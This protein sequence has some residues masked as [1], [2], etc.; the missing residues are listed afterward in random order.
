MIK[1]CYWPGAVQLTSSFQIGTA[2]EMLENTEQQ[3]QALCIL[4]DT[5]LPA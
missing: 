1:S 2:F 4:R 3:A 5:L